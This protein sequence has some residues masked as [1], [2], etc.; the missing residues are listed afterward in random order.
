MKFYRITS[1]IVQMIGIIAVLTDAVYGS[2]RRSSLDP[3]AM[4]GSVP[5]GTPGMG[6]KLS[7]FGR[8]VG[9]LGNDTSYTMKL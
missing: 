5:C 1:L 3:Y 8:T 2:I 6:V 4:S 9:L 7:P